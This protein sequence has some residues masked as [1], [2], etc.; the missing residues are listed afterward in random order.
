MIYASALLDISVGATRIVM[1]VPDPIDAI[2][3]NVRTFRPWA[4][5]AL[6]NGLWL[7]GDFNGDGNSD[8]LHAVQNSDYVHVW[9]SSGR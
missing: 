2:N 7:V 8:I 1:G 9:L 4:G 3:F 6:P 5:Y